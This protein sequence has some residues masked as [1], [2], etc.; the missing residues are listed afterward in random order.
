MT[1]EL[2]RKPTED[3]IRDRAYEMWRSNKPEGQTV[4]NEI[5][6]K[7]K[8]Q[9]ELEYSKRYGCF[10]GC[11]PCYRFDGD[12]SIELV[13]ETSCSGY[14]SSSDSSRSDSNSSSSDYGNGSGGV[15][16]SDYGS[17][18]DRE[19]GGTYGSYGSGRFGW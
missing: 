10:P 19:T 6:F 7:A 2:R 9:L 13:P 5:W 16:N 3:E 15:Y 1:H 8:D 12:A 18:G 4:S 17:V 11:Y 14:G